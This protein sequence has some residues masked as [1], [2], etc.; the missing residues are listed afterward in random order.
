MFDD[1]QETPNYLMSTFEFDNPE[2]GN[3][4]K[5][6]LQFET[7]HW[8]SNPEGM[9]KNTEEKDNTY[10]TG[11]SNNIGNL[12]YGS[13]GYMAKNVNRWE[14]YHG[15]ERVA[16]A[17]GEGLSNHYEDF[18]KA[19]RANNQSLAM[20]DIEEGFYS[21]A[22]IHLGNISYRL[23]R[24]LDFDPKTMNFINDPEANALLTRKYRAPFIVPDKV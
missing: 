19:I 8:I 3:D 1:D 5:K 20:G 13:G 17:S 22:L 15:K 12:F 2:G 21:C 6:I 16:T 10:M 7:R 23:G 9:T 4:K 24:S 18:C 14:A 11:S